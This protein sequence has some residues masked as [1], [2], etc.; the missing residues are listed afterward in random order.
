MDELLA[1]PGERPTA[2]V[3]GNDLV[4]LRVIRRLRVHGLRCPEDVSVAG[5]NDMPLAEDFWPPLTTVHMSLREIGAEAARVL[6]HGI[7]SREQEPA[8]LTVRCR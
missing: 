3:G 7:E 6:L 8:T 1:H 5:F 4:V 2:V